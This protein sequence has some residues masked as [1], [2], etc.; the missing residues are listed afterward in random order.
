M[1]LV[2]DI[3]KNVIDT[4]PVF[5]VVGLTDLAV[6]KVRD[7]R[8]KATVKATGVRVDLDPAALQTKAQVRV[9]EAA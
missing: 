1:A 5:A 8:V 7:A 2:A 4:T 9:T 3:R 6:E